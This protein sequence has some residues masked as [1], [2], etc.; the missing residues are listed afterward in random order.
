MSEPELALAFASRAAG[1]FEETYRRHAPILLT[2]ARAVLGTREDAADCVHDTLLRVWTSPASYR[3]ERGPLRAFLIVCVRNAA[4]SR[5]RAALRHAEL[6]EQLARERASATDETIERSDPV[7]RAR[8]DAAL[9]AL[10]AEQRAVIDLA[11]FGGKSQ[12][13]IAA[14]LDLPL[15]TVKSRASLGLRKLALALAPGAS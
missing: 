15:G 13:E 4:L 8:L 9:R 2:V 12:T 14:A 1:A 7:E 3:A 11:Y 6:D 5:R 10:P